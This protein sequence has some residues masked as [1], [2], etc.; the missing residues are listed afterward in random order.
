MIIATGPENFVYKGQIISEWNFGVF[1][2][3]KKP[4][5]DLTDFCP[6][7]L[8]QKSATNLTPKFHSEII[9]PLVKG[10][11]YKILAMDIQYHPGAY[12]ASPNCI[13]ITRKIIFNIHV[14]TYSL[15]IYTL[16]SAQKTKISNYPKLSATLL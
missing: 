2:S 14:W 6:M 16:Q 3:P 12:L 4:T 1:K 5:K 10:Y 15:S 9:W 11:K 8:G 13:L 7:N